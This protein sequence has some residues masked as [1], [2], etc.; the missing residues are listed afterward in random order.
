M[1]G[2][3]GQRTDCCVTEVAGELL[4]HWVGSLR[5]ELWGWLERAWRK[6]GY[7]GR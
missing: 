6:R 1:Q 7:L 3:F 2:H 4:R 5:N